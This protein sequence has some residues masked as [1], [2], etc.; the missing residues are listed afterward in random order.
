MKKHP[1]LIIF[2]SILVV[3]LG[4][5]LLT[6][7]FGV[8]K[9]RNQWES[10]IKAIYPIFRADYKKSPETYLNNPLWVNKWGTESFPSFEEYRRE[11]KVSF[12]VY[13]PFVIHVKHEDREAVHLW[14]IKGY[15]EIY[16][17]VVPY[18]VPK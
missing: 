11:F 9:L 1:K 5:Y 3:F 13:F 4:A 10:Q 15:K 7:V 16:T 8:G 2:I 12:R 14:Y 17:P 6:W 18:K